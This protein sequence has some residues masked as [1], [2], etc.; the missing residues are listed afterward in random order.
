MGAIYFV[1]NN[2]AFSKYRQNAVTN[3]P[4]LYAVADLARSEVIK[5]IPKRTIAE[6]AIWR[7]TIPW[8]S[9]RKAAPTLI[10]GSTFIKI[11]VLSAP[12]RA[13]EP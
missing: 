4:W 13:I 9:T 3:Q 1:G 6:P 7:G 12:K 11:A 5:K 10:S 2:R 8:P